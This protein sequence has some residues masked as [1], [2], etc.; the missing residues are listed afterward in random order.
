[1][2]THKH[3]FLISLQAICHYDLATKIREDQEQISMA[4]MAS[5]TDMDEST[6]SRLLRHAISY[7]VF[8]EPRKGYIAHTG[9]SKY[10]AENHH[11]RQWLG[12]VSGEMWPAATKVLPTF[13]AALKSEDWLIQRIIDCRSSRQMAQVRRT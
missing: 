1:M 11:M 9:A 7:H 2:S 8:H 4:E 5:G 6:V 10:L 13:H 3:N 12:M